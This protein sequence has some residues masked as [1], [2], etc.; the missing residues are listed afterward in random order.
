MDD[1]HAIAEPTPTDPAVERA[2][3]H[4]RVLQE[5][6]ELGMT[7]ARAVTAQASVADPARANDLALAF[8]RIA[9]A[10][11]QT[12]ALEAR[13]AEDRKTAVTE[14]AQRRAFAA[15][16]RRSRVEN[17][18]ERAI[19]AEASDAEAENLYADLQE[20]L[21]DADDLAG[22]YDRSVP[23]IVALICKDLGVTPPHIHWDDADWGT[24][25]ASPPSPL[26]SSR[27][28]ALAACPGPRRTKLSS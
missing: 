23:E 28:A 1:A 11:R 14:I 12:L 16:D 27:K 25:E 21:E 7:H 8:S 19:D 9:R 3:R 6:A 5:L 13:L 4:G 10:V 15:R 20:R 22:F 18:V 2:E 24:P 17:L 26:G